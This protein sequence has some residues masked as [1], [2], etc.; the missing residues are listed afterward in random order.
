MNKNSAAASCGR[1]L[2]AR[3]HQIDA[4]IAVVH[5]HGTQAISKIAEQFLAAQMQIIVQKISFL[6]IYLS[7]ITKKNLSTCEVHLIPVAKHTIRWTVTA[8][9]DW[10]GAMNDHASCVIH[11]VSNIGMGSKTSITGFTENH[12]NW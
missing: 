9:T 10:T 1:Q 7:S 8:Q 11:K 12:E 6:T 2:L 5:L 3:L 4:C